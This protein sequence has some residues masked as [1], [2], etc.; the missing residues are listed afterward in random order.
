ML[1]EHIFRAGCHHIPVAG[2]E[3]ILKAREEILRLCLTG[4]D[5]AIVLE[6]AIDR[7][8]W[9]RHGDTAACQNF[10]EAAR[11]HRARS[12]YRVHVQRNHIVAV[13]LSRF[14]MVHTRTDL[15][16][17]QVWIPIVL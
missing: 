3:A 1:L 17:G 8:T 7:N 6:V 12:L 9:R 2:R 13:D 14:C 4:Y 10:N 5:M 15:Q 11:E 16:P